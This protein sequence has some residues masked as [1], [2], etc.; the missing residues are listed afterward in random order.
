M[1]SRPGIPRALFL[2][3]LLILSSLLVFGCSQDSPLDTASPNVAGSGMSD[4]PRTFVPVQGGYAAGPQIV[5]PFATDRVLVKFTESAYRKSRLRAS[6]K[7]GAPIP[8]ALTGIASV[9]ALGRKIGVVK[10]SRAYIDVKNKSEGARLGVERWAKVK[11]AG[12][13]SIPDVVARYQAD[14]NVESVSPDWIAFPAAVPTD[15]LYPDHW[16]HNNTGQLPGYDWGGTWDHTGPPVGTPGFDTNAEAAWDQGYGSSNVVIAIL[17]SG[18]DKNHPDLTQV[19]GWDFGDNDSNPD[20]DSASPGHGTACAGVAAS[21]ANNG[22]GA[23]GAAPGAVI[24]PVKVADSAGNMY[25]SAI[26]NALYWAAD[27]GADVIS[28]SFGAAIS[29]DPATD[30]ALQYAYNAGVVLLAATGN[31][32]ASTISYPAINQYVIG[33][34]AASPCGDRKRSSKFAFETNPGV[35]TDPNGYTC[36]G[37]RWWGSNYGSNSPDAPGAVDIIAPTILPTTDI[38]GGGGYEPGDYT[39]YFNGTSAATPYAAGVCALIK[40]ANPGWTPA[41]IRDQLVNTAIDVVNVESGS[42][43]DRYSGYGMVDAAAAVGGGGPSN[44]PP[45]ANANGPYTGQTGS[46]VSFSSA[47]SNDPDGTIVGYSWDFGDGATSTQANP[48]HTYGAAGTYTVTLTVT[49]DQ[50]ATGSNSTSAS[51]TD[52]P[53]NNPPVADFSGSP[54]SGN[55]PLTVSFTDLSTNN[56]TSWSWDF[57]DGGTST[58]Q[59]PSYTY[60]NAGTYSVTLTVSNANGSDTLT[61]NGY[62]T[63]NTPPPPPPS[64]EG[65]ILSR[66][67]DFSTDDRSFTTSETLYMKIWSDRVDFTNMRKELWELKDAN[68]QR[69]RQNLTNN[70]DGTWTASFALSGL[71]SNATTWTWKGQV[72]DQ[73]R[74]KYQP[75]TT[76]TVTSGGGGGGNQSPT[77]NAN[78]PYS[79]TTGN[80]VSFSSAGSNDPDGTIVGY[81]WDFGDGATSTQANPS[82]TYSAAGTYTVTLT[83]TDDQG[84]T[85][86]NSTTATITTGGGGGGSDV[87]TITKAEW[88]SGKKELKVEAVSDNPNAT[89]T[90]VGW[91]VMSYDSNKGIWKFRQKNVNSAPATVTVTSDFGGSDT[92][93]VTI[94]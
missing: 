57:G 87:V 10:V 71:P 21:N 30:A 60:N 41:Q 90:V 33:V 31:E 67:P 82:H 40:S 46:P 91:G 15:P 43:W 28:M 8:G 68:K 58:A 6:T 19:A 83:V 1:A 69:V 61:R 52:P 24:M 20:D 44:Q 36:D 49:D 14:P 64:G 47:G 74:T 63:V 84:A 89:L 39:P 78:G 29:S 23:C 93:A 54:T 86:S 26:Q 65:F 7:M 45:V 59:N 92:S 79:G 48:S 62:I 55:A 73:S 72:E 53:N 75:T 18:V 42:G 13:A 85:G 22:I 4:A 38:S 56:P 50:G 32:N 37:E 35:N 17:D 76:I 66:N 5:R 27:N 34:G 11:L 88:N 12:N 3:A 81:S 94:K 51:I 80:P 77:A 9:D 2:T 16:G 25:F 70:G